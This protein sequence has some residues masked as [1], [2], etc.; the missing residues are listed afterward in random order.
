MRGVWSS[1]GSRGGRCRPGGCGAR[2]AVRG[3]GVRGS[4]GSRGRC[5]PGG[6]GARAAVRGAG[7]RGCI[8]GRGRTE[9][10][11]ARSAPGTVAGDAVLGGLG[12]GWRSGRRPDFRRG[13]RGRT[14]TAAGLAPGPRGTQCR[15]SRQVPQGARHRDSLGCRARAKRARDSHRPPRPPEAAPEVHAPGAPSTA[16]TVLPGATRMAGAAPR[17]PLGSRPCRPPSSARGGPNNA[18]TPTQH[19]GRQAER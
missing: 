1:V 8:G 11:T 3:A 2:A 7:V 4:V 10:G 6:C 9:A 15:R 13:C 19:R 17:T 18:G 12:A 14:Q 16:G 5:R